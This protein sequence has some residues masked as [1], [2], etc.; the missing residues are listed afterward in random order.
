MPVNSS[1]EFRVR[2]DM[3][4]VTSFMP[5]WLPCWCHGN[6][7]SGH[8]RAF[9]FF[10]LK[11]TYSSMSLR[12]NCVPCAPK[13]MFTSR[14]VC[15]LH[16]SCAWTWPMSGWGST[17]PRCFSS[18]SRQSVCR[19]ASPWRPHAPP[20]TS[21]ASWTSFFRYC[22]RLVQTSTGQF[23]VSWSNSRLQPHLETMTK[24]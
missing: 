21:Q 9:V 16:S 14:F 11:Q 13:C 8:N 15:C 24:A 22:M 20:P 17:S 2:C 1:H 18:R 5:H 6:L 19:R 10:F 7:F 12:R 23:G 4:V 3:W